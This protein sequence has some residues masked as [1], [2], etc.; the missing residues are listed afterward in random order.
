M[1]T[2]STVCAGLLQYFFNYVS[3]RLYIKHFSAPHFKHIKLSNEFSVI[4]C[5][6]RV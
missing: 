1:M 3:P 2:Y 6:E 5:F 4:R